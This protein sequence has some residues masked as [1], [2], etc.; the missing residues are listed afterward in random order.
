MRLDVWL[1]KVCLLKS[2]SQAKTGCQ[3]GKI[4]LAGE[5]VKESRLLR[6][7]DLLT[8]QFPSKSVELRVLALPTGNVSKKTA[9]DYY[10]VISEQPIDEREF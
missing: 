9:A 8:L 2:R 5:P 7:G 1:S 10:E 3:S 4:L 6:E